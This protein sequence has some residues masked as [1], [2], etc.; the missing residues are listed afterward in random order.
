MSPIQ[1]SFVTS[2]YRQACKDNN[3]N[4]RI[5]D[6]IIILHSRWSTEEI[7]DGAREISKE[8]ED[9]SLFHCSQASLEIVSTVQTLCTCW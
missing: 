9:P 6:E 3:N 4:L 2:S 8:D 5:I 1:E 7:N